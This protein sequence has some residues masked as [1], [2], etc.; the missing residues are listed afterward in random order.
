M[1]QL[2]KKEGMF[3]LKLFKSDAIFWIKLKATYLK[4]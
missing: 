4:F 1:T 3:Y 2:L